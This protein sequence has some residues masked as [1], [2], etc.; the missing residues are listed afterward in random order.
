M[1]QQNEPDDYIIATN[2]SHTVNEFIQESFRIAGLDAQ[3]YLIIDKGLLR[4]S[5]INIV[6]GDYSKAKAKLGWEPKVRFHQLVKIMV[7]ADMDGWKRWTKGERF[8]WDAVE[9]A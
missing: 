4:P 5:D 3:K 6:Q 9:K 7:E 8:A 1:L 2:E